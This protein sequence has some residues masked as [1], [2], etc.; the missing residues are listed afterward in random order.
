MIDDG[1]KTDKLAGGGRREDAPDTLVS[2]GE[3]GASGPLSPIEKLRGECAELK[4][5]LERYRRAIEMSL[6]AMVAAD[7]DGKVTMWNPAA[8]RLFGYS[9]EEA[10]GSNIELL[11]PPG[12]KDRH[13]GG[14]KRFLLTGEG[15]IIG[16][17]VKVE[18]LRKDGSTMPIEMSL[19]AER[20]E[21]RWVFMAILRDDA[22]RRRLEEDMKERLVEVER[23]AKTM[24]GR[25]IKME[26]LRKEIARLRNKADKKA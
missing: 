19:S 5:L 2:A 26:D 13:R 9:Q 14:M 6:D 18:G 4:L 15:P 22:E 17:V 8:E 12:F 21:G 23:L 3:Y 10:L 24:V 1:A 20:V 25:E 11:V 7:E 16:H